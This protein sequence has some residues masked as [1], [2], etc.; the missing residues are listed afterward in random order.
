MATKRHG[1]VCVGVDYTINGN[2]YQIVTLRFLN[3][4]TSNRIETYSMDVLLKM[5]N[6]LIGFMTID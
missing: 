3:L 6:G 4:Y 5:E 2:F 1:R